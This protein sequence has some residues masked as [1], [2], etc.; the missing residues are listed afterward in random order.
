MELCAR[1]WSIR[2]AAREVGV[3]RSSG[4]NWTRGHKTYRNGVVVGFVAPLDRLAVRETSPRYLSQDERIEIADLRRAG[5]SIRRIA[6]EIVVPATVTDHNG[7]EVVH[8]D[9]TTCVTL[10]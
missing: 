7:V 8:A 2:A 6:A 1:G 9:I 5:L 3:S 10:A 4:T